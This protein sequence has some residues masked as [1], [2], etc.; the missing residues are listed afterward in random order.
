MCMIDDAE[1][2]LVANSVHPIARKPHR[3]WECGRQIEVGERYRR[4]GIVEDG[5]AW[6]HKACLHCAGVMDTLSKECRGVVYGGVYED[7][8]DHADYDVAW[9][10]PLVEGMRARWRGRDGVLMAVPGA[11]S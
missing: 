1:M 5:T 7:V 4:T 6:T 10:I 9:A 11:S 3:C 2:V 8:A